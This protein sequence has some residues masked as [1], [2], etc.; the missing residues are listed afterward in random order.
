MKWDWHGPVHAFPR[1]QQ[2]G[3]TAGLGML[4]GLV[5]ADSSLWGGDNK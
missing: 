5:L 4:R 1:T 3:V 2:T